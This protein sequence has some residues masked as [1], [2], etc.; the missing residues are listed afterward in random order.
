MAVFGQVSRIRH[1]GGRAVPDEGAVNFWPGQ[2]D[3]A[4]YV[5]EGITEIHIRVIVIVDGFATIASALEALPSV[6]GAWRAILNL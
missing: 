5:S 1:L 2:P 3:D 6:E 4:N